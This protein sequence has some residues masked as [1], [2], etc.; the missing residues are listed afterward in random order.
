MMEL[1]STYLIKKLPKN[2]NQYNFHYIRQGY[3]SDKEKSL[4]IRQEGKN[5]TLTKKKPVRPNDF[6]CFKESTIVIT[7]D[8]FHQLWNSVIKFLEKKR[9]YYKLP[10]SLTLELDIFENK[11]KGLILAEIEFPSIKKRDDF[12]KPSWFGR[13][14]TQERWVAGENLAGKS[15]KDIKENLLEIKPY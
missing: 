11:L 5:Y 14:V 8:E 4:R 12:H 2:L 15:F 9:Y 7:K 13:D 10:D 3:F 1:E 6:S